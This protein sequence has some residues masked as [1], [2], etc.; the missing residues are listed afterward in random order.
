[1]IPLL[2]LHLCS[3]QS[4]FKHEFWSKLILYANNL[5]LSFIIIG[6]FNEIGSDLDKMGG[7]EFNSSRLNIL[8]KHF[9][10]EDCVDIPFFGSRFTWRKKK[11]G[12]NNIFERLDKV[13][14]NIPWIS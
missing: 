5:D 8:N 1:M 2:H 14:A 4:E 9:S 10:Q 11:G 3:C 6:D 12:A 7:A 13:V